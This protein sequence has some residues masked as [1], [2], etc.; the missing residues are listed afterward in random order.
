MNTFRVLSY[1]AKIGD[2]HLLDNGIDLWTALWN[3]EVWKHPELRCSHKEIWIPDPKDGYVIYEEVINGLYRSVNEHNGTCYTSTMGR[4]GGS[5]RKYNGVCKRPASEVLIHP[6]R[7]FY[8]EWEAPEEAINYAIAWAEKEIILNK[9]YDVLDICKYFLPVRT[10]NL[11][12]HKMICSGF[13]WAFMC[14]AAFYWIAIDKKSF[15]KSKLSKLID[16]RM[17][18]ELPSPV[19]LTLWELKAGIEFRDL[20]TENLIII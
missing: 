9:G 1:R 16:R 2:G 11:E 17:I 5:K 4:A 18:T 12:D 10:Q 3:P 8:E 6:E 20:K 14:K 15:Y 7:W 19:R 13:T